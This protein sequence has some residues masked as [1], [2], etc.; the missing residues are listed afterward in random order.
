MKVALV[1]PYAWDR[2]GGVQTHVGAL[3]DQLARRGHEAL[4]IAPASFGAN[5][6]GS[7]V[8]AG[9]SL[10]IPANGSVAPLSFGPAAAAGVRSA[11][12]RFDPDVVHAHEPLIPSLSLIATTLS[13]APV[14]G[15]F[16]AA[17]AGSV[18]YHVAKPLLERAANRLSQRTAVSDEARE[19]VSKYFPGT[20]RLTPNGVDFAKYAD[21]TPKELGTGKKVLFLSRLERRKGIEVL[22]QAFTRLR[23]ID[24]Q[25]VIAGTGPEERAARKLARELRVDAAWL[26]RV[27]DE[28]KAS[29]FKAADVYCAP[30][31]SGESF[32][33]VLLEAMAA[34]RPIVASDIAG[35]TELLAPAG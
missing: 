12:S 32:G 30:A 15:T 20:Y 23:D 17:A 6:N 29:V 13:R 35:Y 7:I 33:I 28:E 5:V 16:H 3:R 10:N 9:R 31:L 27:P 2:V 25:L 11:L 24:A 26:G 18:G 4:V 22:L 8:R 21:A 34:G 1:C 14:V 19:L